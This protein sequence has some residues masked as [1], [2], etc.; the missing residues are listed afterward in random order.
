M[1]ANGQNRYVHVKDRSNAALLRV[2]SRIRS[3]LPADS[4]FWDCIDGGR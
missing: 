1:L 4:M 3:N 2:A